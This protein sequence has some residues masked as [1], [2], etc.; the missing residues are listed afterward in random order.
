MTS[1]G[2]FHSRMST[3]IYKSDNLIAIVDNNKVAQDNITADLKVIEP[4]DAPRPR[5]KR[6][7]PA[8]GSWQK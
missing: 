6:N 5:E 2:F 7:L 3:H 8:S 1:F 4:I